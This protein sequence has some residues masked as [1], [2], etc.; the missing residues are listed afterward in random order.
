MKDGRHRVDGNRETQTRQAHPT[1]SARCEGGHRAG[2]E[3]IPGQAKE[4]CGAGG[5]DIMKTPQKRRRAEIACDS[6]PYRIFNAFE[7][8]RVARFLPG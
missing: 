6:W 2:G 4:S 5:G 3:E 8:N 7:P 1:P